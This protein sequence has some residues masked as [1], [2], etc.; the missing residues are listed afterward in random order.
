MGRSHSH[1]LPDAPKPQW[2]RSTL[3]TTLHAGA[4]RGVGGGQAGSL[5]SGPVPIQPEAQGACFGLFATCFL[6]DVG[7]RAGLGR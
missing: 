1:S 2:G 3:A 6:S 4:S 5:P 7:F